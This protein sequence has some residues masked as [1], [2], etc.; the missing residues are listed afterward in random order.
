M[1]TLWRTLGSPARLRFFL[2][3]FLSALA[4][5]SGVVLLGLTE[6]DLDA[7]DDFERAPIHLLRQS[8]RVRIGNL[9]RVAAFYSPTGSYLGEDD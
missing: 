8:G 6:E 4:G 9:E 5:A 3:L 2:A 7:L 1:L